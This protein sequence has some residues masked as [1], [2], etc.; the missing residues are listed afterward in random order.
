MAQHLCIV[1]R[2][3]PLLLGYLNIA[4]E[5]LTRTG[6]ELEIVIDRRPNAAF[7]SAAEPVG[8][9]QRRVEGVDNL[10]RSRGYAIVSRVEGEDWRLSNAIIPLTE[11]DQAASAPAS[12]AARAVAVGEPLLRGL[13]RAAGAVGGPLRRGV[14]RAAGAV[15]ARLRRGVTH[16]AGV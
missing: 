1:S 9:E 12:A 8:L 15:G 3:N 16:A 10:L 14:T 13:R 5:Y 2:D 7:E 6:D 11:D 4:L